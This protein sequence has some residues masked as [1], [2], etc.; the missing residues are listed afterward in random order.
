MVADVVSSNR[1]RALRERQGL[2]KDQLGTWVGVHARTIHRWEIGESAIP[3]YQKA[4]LADL[5]GVSIAHLMS[6]D[7]NGDNGD[8]DGIRAVA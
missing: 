5:F 2:S 3:D 4:F 1:L 6:W 8:N 7:E